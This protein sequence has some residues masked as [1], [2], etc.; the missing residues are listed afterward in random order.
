VVISFLLF[1]AFLLAKREKA[2]KFDLIIQKH[3]N[4]LEVLCLG[5]VPS[6]RA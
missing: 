3:T 4:V 2:G 6:F 5:I 1:A